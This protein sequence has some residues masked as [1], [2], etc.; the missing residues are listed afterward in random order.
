LVGNPR[1]WM[2]PPTAV[3]TSNPSHPPAP[4]K[5]S[6]FTRGKCV[7]SSHFRQESRTPTYSMGSIGEHK[8]RW[9]HLYEHGWVNSIERR[10]LFLLL[11]F[12]P[13]KAKSYHLLID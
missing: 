4:R 7:D 12:L 5:R 10:G 9:V 13:K 11:N 2:K 8:N 1:I 3:R 6:P